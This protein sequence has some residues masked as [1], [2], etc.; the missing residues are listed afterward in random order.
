MAG[1]KLLSRAPRRRDE[2]RKY[3]SALLQPD[4]CGLKFDSAKEIRVQ[5]TSALELQ[6]KVHRQ[7]RINLSLRASLPYLRTTYHPIDIS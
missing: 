1:L 6:L 5:L 7:L 4:I 3:W 2:L